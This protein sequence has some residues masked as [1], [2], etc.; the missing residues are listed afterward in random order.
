MSITGLQLLLHEI[1]F[2]EKI[3]I[4]LSTFYPYDTYSL[5]ELKQQNKQSRSKF[6]NNFSSMGRSLSCAE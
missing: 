1:N 6:L 5:A 4:T 3:A 2:Y